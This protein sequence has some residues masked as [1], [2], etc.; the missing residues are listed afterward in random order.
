MQDVLDYRR[1]I[2]GEGR[3]VQLFASTD[4]PTLVVSTLVDAEGVRRNVEIDGRLG[5]ELLVALSSATTSAEQ[6]CPAIL[7]VS[8]A[9]HVASRKESDGWWIHIDTPAS[10]VVIQAGMMQRL[11][12]SLQELLNDVTGEYRRKIGELERAFGG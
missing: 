9:A 10:S 3:H 6:G 5:A 1:T 8:Q 4:P 7:A 2:K 12:V 11:L